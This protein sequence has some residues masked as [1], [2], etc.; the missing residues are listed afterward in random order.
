MKTQNKL[1]SLIAV[2]GILLGLAVNMACS[3]SDEEVPKGQ[4]AEYVQNTTRIQHYDNSPQFVTD[5]ETVID[6]SCAVYAMRLAFWNIASNDFATNEPFVATPED[7]DN[8]TTSMYDFYDIAAS[9]TEK[10]EQYEE[11]FNRLQETG[12]LETV[13]TSG[14]TRGFL[15]DTF[16][17]IFGLKK[18]QEVGRK[19][20]LAVIQQSGWQNDDNKL[21]HLFNQVNPKRR[22]GYT[23]AR[24]FWADFSQGKLDAKSNQIFQ[25]L[26][27]GDAENFGLNARELGFSPTGNMTKTAAMLIEKGISVVIDAGPGGMA[28]SMTMGK[29][30]YNTYEATEDV[31]KHTVNGTLTQEEAQRLVTQWASNLI[32]YN[33]K[34]INNIDG[35]KWD[36]TIDMWD[37]PGDFLGQ[38]FANILLNEPNE[39]LTLS[40]EDYL[41]AVGYT[42]ITIKTQE[43]QS[44]DV[45]IVVGEDGKARIGVVKEK[46]GSFKVKTDKKK[47]KKV[48][49]ADKNGHRKTTEMGADEEEVT[50]DVEE[51]LDEPKDGYI[52]FSPSTFDFPAEGGT[53]R[54]KLTTNYLYYGV[55]TSVD[56]AYWLEANPVPLSDEFTI[57]AQ[58]NTTGE[59]RTGKIIV[60]ATNKQGKV[61]KFITI[62]ATQQPGSG[63]IKATPN[64]LEFGADGGTKSTSITCEGFKYLDGYL[65]DSAEGWV[66]L[67]VNLD[68][69]VFNI[70]V[71]PNTTGAPRTGKVIAY[72]CNVPNPKM[73]DLTTTAIVIRQE[74]KESAKLG[75]AWFVTISP[76]YYI[77]NDW[78]EGMVASLYTYTMDLQRIILSDKDLIKTERTGNNIHI[79]GSFEKKILYDTYLKNASFSF[80]IINASDDFTNSRIDNLKVNITDT[81]LHTENSQQTYSYSA[82]NIPFK[83]S[84]Y[85]GD[86]EFEGTVEGGLTN[87]SFK[88]TGTVREV[89]DDPRNS[90]NI[91]IGFEKAKQ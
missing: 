29:D 12:V 31:V 53:Q 30:L 79:E 67:D 8:N 19:S 54:I 35:G 64:T 33:D 62:K 24:Q 34:I 18:S 87:Y 58:A 43:G 44:V 1:W 68:Q 2:V 75:N 63:I 90:I 36:A 74:A 16:S 83:E 20:V 47:K 71:A 27:H 25:D 76:N 15:S 48:T 21:Q 88:E 17:F 77:Y 81:S 52:D 73:E 51:E 7:I 13:N 37:T 55:T 70:T 80:D 59:P 41:D 72:G 46:D 57:T 23:N 78:D 11:A 65:D 66:T 39:L 6:Y 60:K 28:G 85:F 4:E 42:Q 32:N 45:A 50:I 91:E 22:Q 9:I 5:L 61:L 49:I 38:E 84:A 40:T 69:M 89:R 3:N 86:V 26:Y 10:A 82:S 14:Q 56:D